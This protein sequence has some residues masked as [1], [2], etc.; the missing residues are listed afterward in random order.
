MERSPLPLQD[1]ID[2]E[3]SGLGDRRHSRSWLRD[4]WMA[5]AMFVGWVLTQMWTSTD[6]LHQ[7]VQAETA[8]K[9]D[10]ERLRQDLQQVPSTYVRQDVFTQVLIRINERL[11]S[12]DNKLER[13]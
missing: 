11:T 7:R 5:V 3:P 1:I 6:W 10:L 8:T 12:I 2:V 13:R 9:A 4:N